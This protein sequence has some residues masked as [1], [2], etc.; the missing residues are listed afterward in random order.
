MAI[1]KRLQIFKRFCLGVPLQR[2][3]LAGVQMNTGQR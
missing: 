2:I 3:S 1:L